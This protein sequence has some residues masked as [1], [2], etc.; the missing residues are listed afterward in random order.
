MILISIPESNVKDFMKKLLKE[1]LFDNFEINGVE[2]I[3]FTKFEISGKLYEDNERKNCTWRE[4]R[5]YIFNIIKGTQKPKIIKIIF[6][7]PKEYL[8]KIHP[9]GASF[10]INMLFENDQICFTTGSSEKN[11]SLDK[12][13]ASNW[14][15]YVKNFFNKNNI[16]FDNIN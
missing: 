10:Y 14:D 11:F 1:T 6:S 2:I 13:V 8:A 12:T 4:L 15:N 9:N 7:L 16:L 5:P 3:S